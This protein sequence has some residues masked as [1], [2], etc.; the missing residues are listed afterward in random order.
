MATTR[1]LSADGIVEIRTGLTRLGESDDVFAAAA[2]EAGTVV[3]NQAKSFAPKKSGA[4]A[5][6]IA[7]DVSK[8]GYVVTAG[9]TTIRYAY[10]FHAIALKRSKGGFT[11][12]YPASKGRRPY[13]RKSRIPNKPFLF[14]AAQVKAKAAITAYTKAVDELIKKA[15]P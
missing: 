12:T 13:S 15:T 9:S 6:T 2:R 4:L 11:F 3:A 7:V 14:Q 8:G 10:T 5:N 1:G